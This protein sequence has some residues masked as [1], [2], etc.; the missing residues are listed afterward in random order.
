MRIHEFEDV[1]SMHLLSNGRKG[2]VWIG[3]TTRPYAFVSPCAGSE[4]ALL[5][6]IGDEAVSPEEQEQLSETIVREGCRYAVCFGRDC[7]SWDDSIDMVG[8]MDSVHGRSG[9]LVMTTWHEEEPLE[10]VI[11]FFASSSRFDDW[12]PSHFVVL[13]VGG[14]G[15]MLAGIEAAVSQRFRDEPA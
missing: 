2:R 11:E 9:P 13:L 1:A 6:V 5:L 14:S 15:H 8:V 4:F 10:D 7:S 12:V 3:R